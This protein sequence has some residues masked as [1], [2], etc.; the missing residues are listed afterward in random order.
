MDIILPDFLGVFIALDQELRVGE[1][2]FQEKPTSP[3]SAGGTK[4]MKFDED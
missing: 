4:R 1:G 3:F 2:N